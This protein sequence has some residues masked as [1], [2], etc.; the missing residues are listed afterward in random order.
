MSL[1][2][3]VV[4]DSQ[5][6]RA[7]KA[8][9][10]ARG[11]VSPGS[12]GQDD[13]GVLLDLSGDQ[14]KAVEWAVKDRPNTRIHA[15]T[16][17]ELKWKSKLSALALVRSH[18]P[19]SFWIFTRDLEIQSARRLFILFAVASGARRIVLGDD[20]GR[21]IV[22]SRP[23]AILFEIPALLIE[24]TIG[25]AVIAVSWICMLLLE[26]AVGLK[27]ISWS[28]RT[29]RAVNA[30]CYNVLYIA[31]NPGSDSGS[32]GMA[33][34]VAGFIGGTRALGHRV[35]LLASGQSQ[36][37]CDADEV[38]SVRPSIAVSPTRATFELWNNLLFTARALRAILADLAIDR[39]D[40][41]Y[42]R[43][44][45]FNWTGVALSAMTGVPLILEFNGSE[46]WVARHWDPVDQQPLL[47]RIERLNLAAADLITVVSD[48]LRRSLASD[49]IDQV[50]VVMNPNGVDTDEF[51]PGC[52][53]AKLRRDLAIDDK[54]VVGFTGSFGP[55]HGTAVLAEA[56]CLVDQECNCHFLFI[57][58]GDER[59]AAEAIVAAA[60]PR[61]SAGFAGR[62]SRREV[63]A[64][65]DAC[66]ILVSPHIPLADGSEF[67]GSPTKLFEYLAMQKAVIASRL[68]Q[69]E[70]VIVDGE[71]GLLVEP[72]DV[73]ALAKQITRLAGDPALRTRLGAAARLS[74]IEKYTWQRNAAR[75]IGAFEEAQH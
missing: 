49:D 23:R 55:W 71:T 51:R 38:R 54:L 17:A 74:A 26:A 14:R 45:R 22:I 16:K 31:A 63:P 9:E 15:I 4:R 6:V 32:G 66:D 72:G 48:A 11:S 1:F 24:V 37:Y 28:G 21:R 56:A 73:A 8:H 60:Y 42:Q 10:R 43:Y 58:D 5:R 27:R 40:F 52:G 3:A 35:T 67:F 57:G 65:L 36:A 30:M 29:N 34:H 13:N 59:P 44:S 39:P 41:I 62:V 12:A 68:G 70:D 33:S 18:T 25:Y 64:Y 46:V 69:I 19:T 2:S 20:L 7:T 75:V 61:V 47:A 50:R 53:G